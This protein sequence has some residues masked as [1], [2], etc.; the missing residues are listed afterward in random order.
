VEVIGGVQKWTLNSNWK[1]AADNF[2]GDSGHGTF[3][4]ASAM[5][6]GFLG[7][8]PGLQEGPMK[9]RG[10]RGPRT[11][12]YEVHPGNGHGIGISWRAD[13]EAP[14]SERGESDV[15]RVLGI[16][17]RY[18]A[19]TL[20]EVER[21]LGRVRARQIYPG[22][23]TVFPNLSGSSTAHSVRLFHPRGPEAMETWS[24]CIVD[25]AAPPEVKEACRLLSVWRFGPAGTWEQDDME[26]WSQ[27]TET[28]RGRVSRR[29]PLNY[30]LALDQERP[31]DDLPGLIQPPPTEL[32]Q[33]RFY[34]RW[35]DLMAGQPWPTTA[36]STPAAQR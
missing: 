8:Q 23:F 29:Y 32:N 21:R 16:V 35:A 2:V 4:H 13:G 30:Q 36:R 7:G 12:F 1:F 15:G 26:N 17:D 22:H 19:E 28:A 34:A 9:A 24:Y 33:R 6:T 3:T 27:C 31:R 18:H 14:G 25:R 20:P 11:D 10:R 5:R